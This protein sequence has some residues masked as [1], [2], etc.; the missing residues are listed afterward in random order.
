MTCARRGPGIRV[1]LPGAEFRSRSASL[2]ASLSGEF[3][4]FA[5]IGTRVC[6]AHPAAG[7]ARLS[8][9]PLA[10][11]AANSGWPIMQN[12]ANFQEPGFVSSAF[13]IKAYEKGMRVLPPRKQS[14]FAPPD[15]W[16]A[17][18]TLRVST[19]H[20]RFPTLR[21]LHRGA[22]RDESLARGLGLGARAGEPRGKRA[23]QSQF[24][25]SVGR[26][27]GNRGKRT[28]F[29]SPGGPRIAD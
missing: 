18:P 26:H 8:A 12:K 20:R 2:R 21:L 1:L 13:D 4:R 6:R 3:R 23:K 19:A 10:G 24:A 29:L 27:D 22:P 16:W 11:K 14:Q 7:P 15:G 25:G 17:L 5:A 9:V 28:Q